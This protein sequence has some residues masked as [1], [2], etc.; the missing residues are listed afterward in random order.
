MNPKLYFFNRI[1]LKGVG[2]LMIIKINCVPCKDK[3]KN[4]EIIEV[5]LCTVKAREDTNL[6]VKGGY[7]VMFTL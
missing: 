5:N 1:R 7:Y 4:A 2:A 3:M 6:T